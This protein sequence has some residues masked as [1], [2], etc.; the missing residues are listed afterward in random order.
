M[1]KN[2]DVWNSLSHFQTHD[3]VQRA[4]KEKHQRSLNSQPTW[5]IAS[6][7][8]QGRGYFESASAAS[9]AVRPLLLYYGVLALS[10][11]I[12]LFLE[13]GAREDTLKSGHG[14]HVHDWKSTLTKHGSE[15]VLD[16]TVN[17]E[18]GTF[19]ELQKAIYGREKAIIPIEGG[20]DI[21]FAPLEGRPGLNIEQTIRF[22]DVLS[23]IPQLWWSYKQIT[24]K[25]PNSFPGTTI[26]SADAYCVCLMRDP[27]AGITSVEQVRTLFRVPPQVE[28]GEWP[29]APSCDFPVIAFRIPQDANGAYPVACPVVESIGT[30]LGRVIVPWDTDVY[31]SPLLKCYLTAYILGMLVRYF[32][33]RWMSV[34]HGQ[35]GDGMLPLLREAMD[36]VD[37]EFPRITL[38]ILA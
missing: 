14:L 5:E 21:L 10:R 27:V 3:L 34:T 24:E 33:S 6:C 29:S 11:G 15:A 8:I 1:A 12:I 22:G 23:R 26:S 36:Y 28:I 38:E 13:K 31:V 2:R 7:F 20:G 25:Q 19:F 17:I 37:R 16:L 32:P 30:P 4:Y 35:K 9:E 18:N